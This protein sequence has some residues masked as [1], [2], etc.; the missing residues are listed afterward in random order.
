MNATDT[1]P[2]ELGKCKLHRIHDFILII[3]LYLLRLH[4]KRL[5]HC[6]PF[7]Q[8]IRLHTLTM[9]VLHCLIHMCQVRTTHTHVRHRFLFVR[10]MQIVTITTKVHI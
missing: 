1:K 5:T 10:T 9:L 3:R 2:N 6:R 7:H 4:R 8:R